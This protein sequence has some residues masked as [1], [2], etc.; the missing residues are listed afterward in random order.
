MADGYDMWSMLVEGGSSTP[1]VSTSLSGSGL[2]SAARGRWGFG[3]GSSSW[4][5]SLFEGVSLV[6]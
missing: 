4:V 1:V 5:S 6:G 2:G 3:S